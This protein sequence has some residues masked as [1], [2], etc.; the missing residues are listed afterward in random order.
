MHRALLFLSST[1]TSQNLKFIQKAHGPK[2]QPPS[3]PGMYNRSPPPHTHNMYFQMMQFLGVLRP[4]LQ[5]SLPG[6]TSKAPFRLSY[7]AFDMCTRL[8]R[9]KQVLFNYYTKTALFEK[10]LQIFFLKFF[11]D[12]QG[13]SLQVTGTGYR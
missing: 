2:N 4:F 11:V 13:R 7:A 10:K 12:L 1:Q 6:S 8:Q 5:I 3:R 9:G